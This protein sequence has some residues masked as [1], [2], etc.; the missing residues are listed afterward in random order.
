VLDTLAVGKPLI[1]I[2]NPQFEEMF[3]DLGDIGYLCDDAGQMRELILSIARDPP[4]ERYR[5]QSEAILAG[6]R[7]FQPAAVGSQLRDI[8]A[9]S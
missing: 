7:I 1:A 4:R 3:R 5:R 9:P 8:L 2:R 6:R